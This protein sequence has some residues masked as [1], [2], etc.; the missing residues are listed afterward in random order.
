[1]REST[2]DVVGARDVLESALRETPSDPVLLLALAHQLERH[3]EALAAVALA[4]RVLAVDVTHNDRSHNDG[5]TL[6]FI[7]FTLA[8]AHA[9]LDDAH[10]HAWRAVLLDPTNG[11]VIDTLGWVQVQEGSLDDAI[12]TLRRALVLSPD[13]GEIEFHLATALHSNHHDDEARRFVQ[14]ALVHLS[15]HDDARVRAEDLAL[16]LGVATIPSTSPRA[17]PREHL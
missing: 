11:S 2:G 5:D 1:V 10:K 13:E 8:E 6:N 7:A 3:G 12:A 9:R 15:A 16:A 14:R 17:A 4:E